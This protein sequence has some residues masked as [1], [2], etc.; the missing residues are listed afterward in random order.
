MTRISRDS[1]R[2]RF[3]GKEIRGTMAEQFHEKVRFQER[4]SPLLTNPPA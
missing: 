3:F 2:D 1:L 4:R